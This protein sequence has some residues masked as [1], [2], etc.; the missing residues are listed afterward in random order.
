MNF[1]K[2]QSVAL[3][4]AQFAAYHTDRCEAVARRLAGRADV[5]AVEVATTS[6]DYAWERSADVPG[7]RKITLFPGQ[8]FDEISPFRRYR[9]MFAAVRRSDFVAIGLS[10][11]E[12]DAI[13]LSWT[14]R[15]LGKKV[16]V[17]SESKFDDKQ[18]SVWHEL[19]KSMI[20]GCYSA[21]IVGAKRHIDYF[22]FLQFRRRPILP[23]YD[24]VNIDR[25]REQAGNAPALSNVDYDM[26]PFVFVGRFVK[27]KNLE[28]LLEGYACYLAL[29]GPPARR[30]ILVGS[31]DEETILRRRCDDLDITHLVDFTGFLTAAEVSR[32]LASSL[33]LMLVSSEEQW[34]LVVNEA[35]AVGLPVVVSHEVGSRD[36]LVRNL[37]NGFVVESNSPAGI[38]NAML[39]LA[40]DQALW[41]RMATAS[42]GRAWLGD[43]ERIADA[44][45][46]LLYPEGPAAAARIALFMSELEHEA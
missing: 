36:A 33:A 42:Y 10:Y 9:A 18:R 8:S 40:T 15:L 45:E 30:L 38:G 11:G 4:W 24:A 5:L 22:R 29:G 37:V 26:R 3:V 39:L 20:L 21:A 32:T 44:V 35:L 19:L 31:G 2:R 46:S 23:G 28:K 7:A 6:K 1:V 27:K 25:V 17:F 43:T 12:T 13:L 41:E 14:L 16:I 34:G